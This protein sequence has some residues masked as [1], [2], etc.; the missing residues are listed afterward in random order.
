M[1]PT[2]PPADPVMC[3][4]LGQALVPWILLDR[5]VEVRPTSEALELMDT[6]WY[7]AHHRCLPTD[8]KLMAF[9]QRKQDHL[10]KLSGILALSEAIPKG[11]E[12]VGDTLWVGLD[13]MQLALRLL[14]LE[15]ARLPAAFAMIG[16]RAEAQDIARLQLY[17]EKQ[18]YETG[19]P[20]PHSRVFQH[21]RH[22]IKDAQHLRHML[23]TLHAGEVIQ[24]VQ[25]AAGAKL[26]Y[27]PK[28]K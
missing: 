24:F 18:W 4:Q 12:Q 25:A 28:G 20:I 15:E 7:P 19:E 10:Y 3:R 2:P 13:A 11:P 16:A 14:E 21:C 27:K 22:F 8:E 26:S 9:W 6:E 5:M 17:I 1:Y 23:D